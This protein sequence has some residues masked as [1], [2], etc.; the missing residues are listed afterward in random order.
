MAITVD[1]ATK[2]FTIPQADLTLVSGTLYTADT[3]AIRIEIY[4][5]LSSEAGIPFETAI[6][7][8]TQVTVAG[9]TYARTIEAINGYQIEFEDGQYSVRLEG[10]NNNLFDVGGGVLVQNQVQVIPTNSAG[11]IETDGGSCDN[12]LFLN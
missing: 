9:T 4:G 12:V 11:L 3:D 10:S 6:N 8:N 2:I 1:W 7:H 5:L